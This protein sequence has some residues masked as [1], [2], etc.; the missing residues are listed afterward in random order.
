VIRNRS[1]IANKLIETLRGND[2]LPFRIDIDAMGSARRFA[3]DGHDEAH[4][5][6]AHCGPENEMQVARM[7]AIDNAAILVVQ[8][9]A[10][11]CG[12]PAA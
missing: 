8:E 1:G 12:E 2:A 10:L 5:T 7:E 3:I 6:A 11:I 4:R 9:R